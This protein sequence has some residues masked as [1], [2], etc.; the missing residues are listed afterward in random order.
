MCAALLAAATATA[1]PYIHAHRGGALVSVKGEQRPL[2]PESSM[3]A[4]REAARRGFVLELDVK[5]SS[6][7]RP[8]VFHDGTLDRT[9][10]CEGPVA[11]RTLRQLRKDCEIDV[12]GADG[13][14]RRL[15]PKDDRRATIPTLRQVLRLARE[16]G[17]EVNI[18]IKNLPTDPDFD[19][20]DGYARTVAEEVKQSAIPPSRVIFQSFLPGNLSVVQNDPYFERAGT[21][22]LTLK[23]LEAAGPGI[24]DG[25]GFDWISPQ[26]PV[27]PGF[28]EEAHA[29]G[30]RVVPYTVDT[31][32]DV[33]TATQAGVDAIVTND[34]RMARRAVRDV[35]PQ[36]PR[37]PK[38]P[39]RKACSAAAASNLATPVESCR[40][41]S[42]HR[43]GLA[44]LI[45]I[46][47]RSSPD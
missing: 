34:P 42:V 32:A 16:R 19:T 11:S 30:L 29:L 37:M 5:L 28:V 31:P 46:S 21:S 17:V 20:T 26:W 4:F 35:A 47:R 33:R 15:G 44:N 36:P 39:G 2:F 7:G 24:A 23:S 14:E 38:P 13:G 8:V 10:D 22:F 6:D 9:T 27:G 12:L 25:A 40:L 45:H 1:A 18:E 3:P 43:V 41:V